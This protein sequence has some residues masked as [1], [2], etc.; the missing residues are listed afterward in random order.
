[1]AVIMIIIMIIIMTTVI[2]VMIIMIIIIMI[3]MTTVIIV[4]ITRKADNENTNNICKCKIRLSKIT[5]GSSVLIPISKLDFISNQLLLR[6][7]L[8]N[9]VTTSYINTII[10]EYY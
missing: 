10:G 7:V 1:M 6:F 4:I 5:S 8:L 9:I 3:I 2:T